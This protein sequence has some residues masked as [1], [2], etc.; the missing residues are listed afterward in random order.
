VDQPRPR[1]VDAGQR[2]D[3]AGHARAAPRSRRRR[4]FLPLRRSQPRNWHVCHVVSDVCTSTHHVT[5]ITSHPS[6][7]PHS[8]FAARA[9]A[10][11]SSPLGPFSIVA[12]PGDTGIPP[13]LANGSSVYL[14][15]DDEEQG[16]D[17]TAYMVNILLLLQLCLSPSPPPPPPPPP[18]SS[19]SSLILKVHNI[20]VR[21][22]ETTPASY[23]PP[24]AP[25]TS[26]SI[27]PPY[28]PRRSASST[29]PSPKSSPRAPCCGTALL[30][31]TASPSDTTGLGFR[32]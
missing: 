29:P 23:V 28:F 26:H 3:T 1:H 17:G 24:R 15:V 22:S 5:P 2:V 18:P 9:V 6:R 27:F 32:I 7:H 12:M 25:L 30:Q 19:S 4:L 20:I 8:F 11:S 31:H 13:A 10:V 14:Y 16:G 21:F